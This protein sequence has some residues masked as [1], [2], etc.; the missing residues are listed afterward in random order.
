MI[1][2]A[3]STDRGYIGEFFQGIPADIFRE[4]SGYS[5]VVKVLRNLL[6][7]FPELALFLDA[8]YDPQ[9]LSVL[10]KGTRFFDIRG[11]INTAVCYKN[12]RELFLQAAS[13]S[14]DIE[15]RDH[16]RALLCDL[17]NKRHRAVQ[18][19]SLDT[20]EDHIRLFFL[21]CCLDLFLIRFHIFRLHWDRLHSF[22]PE[23]ADGK[24][25]FLHSGK[26]SISRNHRHVFSRLCHIGT[27]NSSGASCT[28]DQILHNIFL[29]GQSA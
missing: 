25:M 11:H 4:F 14:I 21:P 26:M 5:A 29:P 10:H 8:K 20:H 16:D 12:S 1:V 6:K 18:G 7:F 22:I 3:C 9:D 28:D 27:K 23:M 24:S 19:I 15:N 2:K 17:P 13:R